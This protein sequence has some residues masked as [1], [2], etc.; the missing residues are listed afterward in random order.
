[1]FVEDDDD[2]VDDDIDGGD[3]ILEF[4]CVVIGWLLFDGD[5]VWINGD[6]GGGDTDNGFGII[7]DG[8]DNAENGV[9]G[10]GILNVPCWGENNEHVKGS[11]IDSS[12]DNL[13]RLL[14]IG[15]FRGEKS[16]ITPINGDWNN[17]VSYGSSHIFDWF[18]LSKISFFFF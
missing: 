15:D 5:F 13:L 18:T 10:D 12:L 1:M 3:L 9:N 8:R 17:D 14:F 16:S 7:G 4:S 6:V 11:F 2:D